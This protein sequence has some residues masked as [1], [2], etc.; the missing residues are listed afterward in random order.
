MNTYLL[1]NDAT[2]LE[3]LRSNVQAQGLTVG[4]SVVR[5]AGQSLS[6]LITSFDAGILV[7][8]S[9]QSQ[10]TDDLKTLETMILR[11]PLVSVILICESDT[12][13]D[14]VRAMRS[15]VREV[16]ALPLDAAD[17]IEAL[18][19]VTAHYKTIRGQTE[20]YV[21]H[22]KIIAFISCKG[23]SG[24]TFLAANMAY[25]MANQFNRRCAFIDLDLQYGD[26]TFY[27]SH[28]ESKNSISDLTQQIERLDA[29][30]LSSCMQ[31]ISPRLNLLAAPDEP[32]V[33]LAIT[34]A[35]LEK[36]LTLANRM[37]EFVVLDLDSTMDAVMLKA[38]DMADV[39]YVVMEG[40]LPV[41]RNA[42]RMVKLFRSLGYSDD[43]L[44]L[45][46]N[47]YQDGGV[48]NVKSIE[49]AVC[50][51][52]HHTIPNQVEA[53]NE[54]FNLGK[55]LDMVHPQNGVLKALREITSDF[56]LAPAPKPQSW[57]NRLIGKVA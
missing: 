44:L 6:R 31:N 42:K 23:G 28:D 39:I 3:L 19:R 37:H 47:K 18:R 36:V 29:Q 21:G 55:P 32:G 45:I 43:K 27:M 2:M 50:L 48:M 38:L 22:G 46:V 57:I 17:L 54:A 34:A 40:S 5:E 16:V 26:A 33:A 53:V 49:Q 56:L 13:E 20:A 4:T 35:Q 10:L 41:V 30:L 14:L 12:K 1:A 11:N 15:G 9:S 51:K 8:C 25:L 24:S 52:V 7:V